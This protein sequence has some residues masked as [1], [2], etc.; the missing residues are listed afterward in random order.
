MSLNAI[1][2][3]SALSPEDFPP[4]NKPEIAF[5]GRSNVGKS[6]LLNAL[7]GRKG[8]AQVSKSPGKTQ[9]IHF[10]EIDGKFRFVDLPGYGFARVSKSLRQQWGVVIPQY[11]KTRP[12]LR[13]V[14]HVI[15]SRHAPMESDIELL[16]FLREIPV[17]ILFAATKSDKLKSSERS[18]VVDVLKRGLAL[19]EEDRFFLFSSVTREGCRELWRAIQEELSKPS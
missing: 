12:T 7:V 13:A 18:K 11:I 9:C 6:S 16:Q 1:L 3:A 15:D 10:Y 2:I 4:A 5:A 19:N 17:S 14:V 8:L